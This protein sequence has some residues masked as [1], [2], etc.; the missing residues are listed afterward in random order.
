MPIS[1]NNLI[2]L[3]QQVDNTF[4]SITGQSIS[5]ID[6]LGEWKIPLNLNLFTDFCKYVISSKIGSVMC[7]DCNHAFHCINENGAN[8]DQCHMGVTMISVPIN[9]NGSCDMLITNAQFLLE[10]TVENFRHNLLANAHRLNLDYDKLLEYSKKIKVLSYTDAMA[11]AQ[12]LKILA[13][14]ITITEAELQVRKNY[15]V[16]LQKKMELENR[17][18]NM[19]FKFLQSQI[20]PH[21]LFN[22]LNLLMRIAHREGA[23]HT[24]DLIYDLADL[25]RWG[26]KNKNSVCPLKDELECVLSYLRIQ[27]ERLGDMLI[28]ETDFDPEADNFLI[29]VLTIQPLVENAI[30][31]GVRDDNQTVNIGVKAHR[32]DTSI[33]I[34]VQDNGAGIASD[35]L[36]RINSFE[37][38]G[39]GIENVVE[40]IRLYFNGKASFN[41]DSAEAKGT[42]ITITCPL[43]KQNRGEGNEQITDHRG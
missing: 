11:R 1:G 40:R 22:T 19:E 30:I 25:L 8:I 24:A 16:E 43:D 2:K 18:K 5:F 32:T 15:Y 10:G 14:Y 42:K 33:V 27:Q 38:K 13:E 12:F 41:I 26:F 6:R 4:T 23:A 34:M 7:R 28:V 39:T 20:S 36:K 21:F 31:H 37:E 29:P 9:L 35:T 17:L 3:L